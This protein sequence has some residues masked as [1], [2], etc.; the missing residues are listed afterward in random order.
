MGHNIYLNSKKKRK[1]KQYIEFGGTIYKQT[2][3]HK[4]GPQTGVANY[5][6]L[7]VYCNN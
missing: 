3:K 1:V 2:T 7:K 6:F 4:N 5:I